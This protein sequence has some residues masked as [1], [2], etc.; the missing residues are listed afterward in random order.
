MTNE[1]GPTYNIEAKII[2]HILYA[3]QIISF[4]TFAKYPQLIHLYIL[5]LYIHL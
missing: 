4:S 3:F 1:L 2:I 5:F